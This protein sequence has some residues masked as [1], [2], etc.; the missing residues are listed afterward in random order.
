MTN[1]ISNVVKS[2]VCIGA[3]TALSG[4]SGCNCGCKKEESAQPAQARAK[5]SSTMRIDWIPGWTN[6]DGVSVVRTV[7]EKDRG[8]QMVFEPGERVRIEWLPRYDDTFRRYAG[9]V[10]YQTIQ[11]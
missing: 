7:D 4:L 9:G 8:W 6:S 10:P 5:A 1:T 2:I 11:R 3:V